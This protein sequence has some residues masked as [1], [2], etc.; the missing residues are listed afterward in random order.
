ME[1]S[2]K[3]PTL[4]KVCIFLYTMSVVLRLGPGFILMVSLFFAVPSEVY[5]NN[6]TYGLFVFSKINISLM[7]SLVSGFLL[8]TPTFWLTQMTENPRAFFSGENKKVKYTPVLWACFWQVSIT[9][10]ILFILHLQSESLLLPSIYSS[11]LHASPI[12]AA[13][14]VTGFFSIAFIEYYKKVL[15]AYK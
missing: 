1:L 11:L 4:H 10:A 13:S 5:A 12:L 8:M 7:V 6:T 9:L 2:P 3:L 14:Y 15:K